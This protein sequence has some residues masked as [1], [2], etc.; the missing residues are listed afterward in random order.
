MEQAGPPADLVA[1]FALP[2]PSLVV[3]ELLGVPWEE[4]DEFQQRSAQQM[5]VTRPDHERLV[6]LQQVYEYLAGLSA[7]ACTD[8]VTTCSGCS[9]ASTA[10]ISPPPS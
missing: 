2:V 10:T 4:R 5:D 8:P 6:L 7:R 9:S 1:D 3:C